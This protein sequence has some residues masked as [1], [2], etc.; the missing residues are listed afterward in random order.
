MKPG[1]DALATETVQGALDVVGQLCRRYHITALEDFLATC[2]T[3]A[4]EQTLNV[5]I[6]GRFKAGKSSFLNHLL[7]RR[8]LPV[9]V[10]PVTTVV[11][12]IEYGPRE[13]AEVLFLDGRTEPVSVERVGDFICESEN[14]ENAKQV[15]RVRVALPDGIGS[16]LARKRMDR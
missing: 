6:F 13:G 12:E 4:E 5:A 16:S 2:K 8:L 15:R 9:G 11:T 14:P 7:G 3:F 1:S 10:V